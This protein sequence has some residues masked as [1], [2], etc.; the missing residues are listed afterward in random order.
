M[1]HTFEFSP[2][3]PKQGFLT[4]ELCIYENTPF[5]A[6]GLK[7]LKEFYSLFR[8]GSSLMHATHWCKS[9]VLDGGL[10]CK[11]MNVLKQWPWV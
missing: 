4:Q 8:E 9:E 5:F 10:M 1:C 2:M 11:A 7:L 6:P 3:T